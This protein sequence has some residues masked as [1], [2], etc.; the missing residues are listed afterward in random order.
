M[1]VAFELS[2]EASSLRMVAASTAVLVLEH[3]L[4]SF[5]TSSSGAA[6]QT[7][8]L[9][10]RKHHEVVDAVFLEEQRYVDTLT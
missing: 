4:V 2:G 1:D 6:V 7:T 5:G 8:D 10:K 9:P 3:S